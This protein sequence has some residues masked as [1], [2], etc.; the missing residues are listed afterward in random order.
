LLEG[1]EVVEIKKSELNSE[2]RIDAEYSKKSY[3][4]MLNII[5]SREFIKIEDFASV[6]DGIHTS[7]PYSESSN[8]NLISATSPRENY[9]D[10]SRQ[11]FITEEAHKLNPRTALKANDIIIS[12]VGTIG[13]CAVVDDSI[14]P[15]NSDR[16]VGIVR[17]STDVSPY[18]VSTFLLSKFGRFQTLRESTGNV[19]LNLFIYKI[20][21]LIIP[22]TNSNFQKTIQEVVQKA[23]KNAEFSR[24]QYK[25]AEQL[26]LQE[27]GITEMLW[28]TKDLAVNKKSFKE[29]FENGGRLDSEYY[30]PKYDAIEKQLNDYHNGVSKLML[31]FEYVKDDFTK[32]LE[33]YNYIEIGDVNI[34][35]GEVEYNY[36]QKG[37][38]PA[39]AKIKVQK[40]DLLVSKVRPYRGAVAIVDLT[41]KNLIASGAFTVLR[42]KS[43]NYLIETLCV[44][45]KSAP[46]KELMM[47]FNVGSS[48][49]V[50]RDEDVLNLPIPNIPIIIQQQIASLIQ[51]SFQLRK[52]SKHLLDIAKQAVEMAIETDEATA[53][54]FI[55]ANTDL[56]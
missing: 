22:V 30:Q 20:R 32:D 26:L 9:F 7:I 52:Q 42:S 12:T 43:D 3:L 36:K 38:L 55:Q 24:E 31:V 11:V 33:G 17:I 25:Y 49:P 34:S 1:L 16:H 54:A 5:K 14:L 13:N 50:I 47:K 39:N 27:L 21:T 51:Q 10:L 48:Y 53:M 29:S 44:L 41:E 28:Q 40:N 8:I 56:E 2:T 45:L 46:Y 35:N 15:A 6:T 23:H 18:Y 37:E 4:A 19:Q